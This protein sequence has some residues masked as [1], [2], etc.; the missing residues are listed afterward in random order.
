MAGAV[1]GVAGR[2]GPAFLGCDSPGRGGCDTAPQQQPW[3][4]QVVVCASRAGA[5]VV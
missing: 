3:L 5:G 1:L 2:E 4:R